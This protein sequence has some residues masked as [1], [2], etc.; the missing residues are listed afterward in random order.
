MYIITSMQQ[1]VIDISTQQAVT[2]YQ[3]HACLLSADC[4]RLDWVISSAH[5]TLCTSTPSSKLP[6]VCPQHEDRLQAAVQCIQRGLFVGLS[7]AKRRMVSSGNL[8]MKT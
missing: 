6:A 5:I 4:A 7:A 2:S 3:R 8:H 1:A